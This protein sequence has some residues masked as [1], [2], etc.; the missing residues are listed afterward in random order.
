MAIVLVLVDQPGQEPLP[1]PGAAG[2]APA[3]PGGRK[4]LGVDVL[5]VRPQVEGGGAR[6]R[7]RLPRV[8]LLLRPALRMETRRRRQLPAAPGQ[9][10]GSALVGEDEDTGNSNPKNGRHW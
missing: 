5:A 8:A 1:D 2:R 9:P 7:G 4:A 3:G 6:G 10:T